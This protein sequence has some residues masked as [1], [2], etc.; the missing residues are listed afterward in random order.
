MAKKKISSDNQKYVMTVESPS[1]IKTIKKILSELNYSNYDVIASFGHIQELAKGSA[2]IDKKDN[3]KPTYVV[4]ESKKDVV[5][6]LKDFKKNGY[7]F[8]LSS[9]KDAEGEKISHSIAEILDLP[10]STTKRITFTEITKKAIK[11]AL[12]NPRTIDMNLVN[13]QTA[14]RVLDRLV[15]FDLSGLL[16][17]K[18]SQNLSAGRVQSVSIR[19][20]IEKERE[21]KSFE[22]DVDFKTTGTFETKKGASIKSILDK[23]FKDKKEA[24]KFLNECI[25]K[26]FVINSKEVKAGKKAPVA[27]FTTSSLQQAAGNKLGFNVDRTTSVSQKL[28]EGGHVSYIRTDSVAIS[29]D[30]IKEISERIVLK[31][32]KEFLT[33]RTFKSK[34][35]AAEAHECIRPTHFELETISGSSDEIRLYDL[36]YKRTLASQMSE[37]TVDNTTLKIGA[38]G[39]KEQ[40]IAKGSIMKFKGFTILYDD[41]D[42]SKEDEN[43]ESDLRALPSVEKGDKLSYK[44]I[45]SAQSFT[46][47]VPRFNEPGLVKALENFGI[48]RPSTYSSIIKTIQARGYAEK[49]DI[50]PKERI[51]QTLTLSSTNNKIEES[52]VLDKFGGEKGKLVPTEVAGVVVDY[53]KKHFP[54]IMDYKFTAETE[55]KLDEIAEGNKE[56]QQMIGEFYEPFSKTLKEAA[57]E[58]GKAGIREIGKDPKTGKVIYARLGKFGPMIQMGESVDKKSDEEKPKFAKLKEGQTIESITIEEALELLIWPRIMGKHK[59]EDVSIAIGRFGP[60]VKVGAVYSSISK[61]EDPSTVTLKRAI[62]IFEEKS[63]AKSNNTIKEFKKE[64]ISVLNGKFGAY[65]KSK[66]G[67]HKIPAGKEADTLTLKD[68]EE[69]IKESKSSPKKKFKKFKKKE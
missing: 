24:N 60:Y 67:N 31:Y 61:E 46:K 4:S 43:E 66:T 52:E 15:G 16:W 58:E 35:S 33:N 51:I 37:A 62:E 32:G 21:I 27:P 18:V 44:E 19:L 20:I 23:R 39:I 10:I 36:I 17:K 22:S 8:I 53:L 59:G 40:F 47:P 9:D 28:Y 5:K 65:I 56:W 34:K 29:E 6:T 54:D 55:E 12:E 1:K 68:C 48:G 42:E 50:E 30:A 38:T 49:K 57:G 11:E 3:F 64:G 25:G 69:I 63:A 14:R 45:V 7:E 41:I 13:A 26:E 2:G